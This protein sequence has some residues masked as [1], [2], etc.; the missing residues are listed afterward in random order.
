MA[1]LYGTSRDLEQ[2]HEK[3]LESLLLQ[4]V[5]KPVFLYHVVFFNCLPIIGMV[6]PRRRGTRYVRQF[7]YAISLAF[8]LEMLRNHRTLLGGNGYMLGMMIA[9]WLVWCTTLFVFMDIEHDFQRIE[10]GAKLA[11]DGDSSPGNTQEM[12][13]QTETGDQSSQ[14]L[15]H[16]QS[17]PRKFS[18]RLEWCAGLLF[19]LRGPEWNWRVPHLGPLPQSVHKHLQPEYL[20]NKFHAGGDATC[21]TSGQ[22]LRAAFKTFLQSYLLLDILKVVMMRDPYFRGISGCD[23]MPPFP[24]SYLAPFPLLVT[25]YRYLLSCIGVYV[26]LNF[27]TSLNPICFLGLSLAFPNASRKL[28]AA[29]LD[30][31]WLYADSFGPFISPVLDHGI[32]GCWG[33]WWHQLFRY[34]FTA[35]ARWICACLP[36][37]FAANEQIKQILYIV[38]AFTISGLIHACGSYTQFAETKPFSGPFLFFSL[39]SIAI[40]CEHIFKKAIFPRIPLVAGTPRWLRRTGNA[41]L[42]FFWLL[43]SGGLYCG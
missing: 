31:A 24:M 38:V 6:I 28:T 26:A 29:P 10:R 14:P 3:Q 4:G 35:T 33:R 13:N 16:W 42:V 40:I 1:D 2:S 8:A 9:W 27:V 23:S 15:F 32:A 43:Y 11:A 39:Q 34:G 12:S 18:H 36:T 21:M 37:R 5:Y 19:N 17:Y 22:R 7:I 25:I 30:E 41:V 20:S